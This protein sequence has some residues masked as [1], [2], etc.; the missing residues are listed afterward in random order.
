ML[1]ERTVYVLKNKAL[2]VEI[3]WLY[4]DILVVGYKKKWKMVELVIRNY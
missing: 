4:H 2:R 3:I 1:K